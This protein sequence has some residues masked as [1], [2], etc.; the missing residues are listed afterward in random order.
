M[1]TVYIFHV[2]A[3][4]RKIGT[5][6]IFSL[7]LG[8][9]AGVI[10][11][12][13]YTVPIFCFFL[14][15]SLVS[16]ATPQ[17]RGGGGVGVDHIIL[18]VG[19]LDSGIAEMERRTG[20]RATYGGAHPG[21]GTRNALLSL[22][23][24]TYVEILAPDP[25]QHV[26]DAEIDAL[27]AMTALKPIGWAVHT[28]D[29]EAL[30]RRLQA[31]GLTVSAAEPG[32]RARPDGTRLEWATFAV[33]KPGH[34]LAPF[35]I[36]WADM[37]RH[38]SRTSPAGCSFGSLQLA[39]ADPAPIEAILAPLRLPVRIRRAEADGIALTLSCPRGRAVFQ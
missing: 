9:P 38:P 7:G 18:G 21:R 37:S 15:L 4:G 36:R 17:A 16:C 5:V 2:G 23:S 26:A 14:L 1:G 24:G 27:R 25:A 34:P 29:S 31:R 30:R 3:R 35:F 20:I 22:G 11:Q 32:T 6:Y 12:K 28:G 39:A 13:I 33:A 8:T 19:D 10:A